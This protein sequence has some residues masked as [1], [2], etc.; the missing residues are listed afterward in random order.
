LQTVGNGGRLAL[1]DVLTG[2][3]RADTVQVEEAGNTS[4]HHEHVTHQVQ[5]VLASALEYERVSDVL[6]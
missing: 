4:Q 1:Q 2:I 3:R 6:G 5:R